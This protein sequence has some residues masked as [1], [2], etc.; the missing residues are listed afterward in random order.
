MK[1]QDKQS[2]ITV[3]LARC[4][5]FKTA[6]E[7]RLK[8]YPHKQEIIEKRLGTLLEAETGSKLGASMQKFPTLQD[9]EKIQNCMDAL[10]DKTEKD[11]KLDAELETFLTKHPILREPLQEMLKKYPKFRNRIIT[12]VTTATQEKIEQ[13]KASVDKT[14][15]EKI[16]IYKTEKTNVTTAT[17]EKIEQMKASVDKTFIEKIVE[18]LIAFI[19]TPS[20]RAALVIQEAEIKSPDNIQISQNLVKALSLK[21][22]NEVSDCIKVY[23]K[24]PSKES[25]QE[26]IIQLGKISTLSTDKDKQLLSPIINSIRDSVVKKHNKQS[27]KNSIQ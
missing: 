25:K 2:N 16:L 8:L 22:Q 4:P 9:T 14:F 7:E 18:A 15:I 3:F 11:K 10:I 1:S 20:E 12:N 5:N 23:N 26:L 19:F 13:M 24:N 6:L 21:T 27:I 17:Q